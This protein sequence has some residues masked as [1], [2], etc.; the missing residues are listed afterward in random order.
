MPPEVK[1]GWKTTEFW[2]T[3]ASQAA[4]LLV[5][6]GFVDKENS[7]SVTVAVKSTVEAL[8]VIIG[9]LYVLKTYVH[10]R[11]ETKVRTA[12]ALVQIEMLRAKV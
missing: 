7:E 11:S 5:L 4:M 6:F 10:K 3:L 8:T 1:P 2:L 12:E 9:N